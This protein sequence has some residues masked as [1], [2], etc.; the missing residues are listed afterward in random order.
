MK[1]TDLCQMIGRI[2]REANWGP[3]RQI[4]GAHVELFDDGSGKFIVEVSD[5]IGEGQILSELDDN[6]LA[7]VKSQEN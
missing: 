2:E 4:S 7:N 5:T 3:G 1:L 6:V